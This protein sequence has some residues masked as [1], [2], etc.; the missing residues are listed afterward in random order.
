MAKKIESKKIKGGFFPSLKLPTN[1][2]DLKTL[3]FDKRLIV[4]VVVL[5]LLA[6]AIY[7]KEWFVAATVNGTPLTNFE[8]L[9]RMNQQFRSQT[10]NQIINE[11][12]ILNEAQKNGVTVSGVEVNDRISQLEANVGGGQ[13]LDSLLAQ[14]GQ[15]RESLKDQLKFQLII[16]KLYSNE[17]TFSAEELD[18]FIEENNAQL[19]TDSAKQKDEGA[20]LLKQQKVSTIFSQKFQELRQKAQIQIF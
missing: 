6:L 9:S 12:I 17:A 8:L 19:S 11:K 16:E 15:T 1:F 20:K 18:Q 4:M 3:N 10:L 14:Q 2:N 7:K 5:A 13:L